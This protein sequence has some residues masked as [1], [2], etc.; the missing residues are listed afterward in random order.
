MNNN[1]P[2]ITSLEEFYKQASAFT[3]KDI[4]SLLPPDIH[5]EIGHFNVFDV[6]QT[7]QQEKRKT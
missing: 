6:A 3:G 2:Y 4:N 7:I 1:E 5:K